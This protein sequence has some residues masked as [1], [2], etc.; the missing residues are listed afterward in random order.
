MEGGTGKKERD[1]KTSHLMNESISIVISKDD[2]Y[3]K[4]K[5]YL[6]KTRRKPQP[7]TKLSLGFSSWGTIAPV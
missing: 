1:R 2:N 6:H 5:E 3:S 7:Q 4:D